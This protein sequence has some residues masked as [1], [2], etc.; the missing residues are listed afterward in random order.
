MVEAVPAAT[1]I[2]PPGHLKF[3]H[4]E[5][6]IEHD[7]GIDR[8]TIRTYQQRL[9]PERANSP[10]VATGPVARVPPLWPPAQVKVTASACEP[11]RAFI[12]AQVRA[13]PQATAI[14]QDLVGQFGFDSAYSSV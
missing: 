6:E 7:T 11:R 12:E 10:G 4:P 13:A 1:Q 8:K 3:L 5:H 2:S 14:Y 9:T